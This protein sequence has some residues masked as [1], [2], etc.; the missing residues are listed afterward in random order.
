MEYKY[1]IVAYKNV[2]YNS[3]YEYVEEITIILEAENM[4]QALQRLEMIYTGFE[5]VH[6]T[7]EG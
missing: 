5:P 6:V 2:T 7:F 4:M 1:R 3:N